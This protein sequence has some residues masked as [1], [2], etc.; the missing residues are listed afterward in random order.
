M[1]NKCSVCG[2]HKNHNG[3]KK[4]A[5]NHSKIAQAKFA[6]ERKRLELL[7]GVETKTKAVEL[8]FYRVFNK[9]RAMIF[10]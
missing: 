7:N 2:K 1:Y 8:P 5:N 10:L 6:E 9:T 4:L 3:D